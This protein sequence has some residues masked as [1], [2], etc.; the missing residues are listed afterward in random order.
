MG[1]KFFIIIVKQ[2]SYYSGSGV[3]VL[4]LIDFKLH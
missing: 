1:N 4:L 3:Q 2:D